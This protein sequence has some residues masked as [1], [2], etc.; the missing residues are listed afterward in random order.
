MNHTIGADQTPDPFYSANPPGSR[1]RAVFFTASHQAT[2]RGARLELRP[3]PYPLPT[4]ATT[5]PLRPGVGA[6][7]FRLPMRS[8]L[9]SIP[10]G[11]WGC[12]SSVVVRRLASWRS[13]RPVTPEVAG[14]SPVARV[15]R[16]AALGART[17]VNS[18][19]VGLA[20]IR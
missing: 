20:V 11:V 19:R 7:G 13:E 15:A 5:T 18:E 8:R 3:S 17:S 4:D 2:F 1:R 12:T 6:L 14:S 9:A 10:H 16:K